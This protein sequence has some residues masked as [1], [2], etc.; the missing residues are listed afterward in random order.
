M[1]E[2][3]DLHVHTN[4]S[5]GSLSPH[6]VVE[7]AAKIGLKAIAVTD[8]DTADGLAEAMEWGLTPDA[9]LTDVEDA[10]DALGELTGRSAKDE[11]VSRIFERFCVGK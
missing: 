9:I 10:L 2:F 5:D 4:A 6:E 8:H 3:I 7:E 11:I 1:R